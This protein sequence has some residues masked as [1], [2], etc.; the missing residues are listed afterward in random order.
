MADCEQLAR[1][2]FRPSILTELD[3]DLHSF[4]D[5]C[6]RWALDESSTLA[7]SVLRNSIA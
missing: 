6:R 3:R 7:V 4:H 5:N 1:S 2:Q